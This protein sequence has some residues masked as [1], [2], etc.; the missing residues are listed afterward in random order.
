MAISISP[1]DASRLSF[2]ARCL[3][4]G[5]TYPIIAVAVD[6]LSI[7]AKSIYLDM[8]G[9]CITPCAKAYVEFGKNPNP[10]NSPMMKRN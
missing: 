6:T 3:F 7:K 4:L 10:T 1:E 5:Y 8:I 9:D 2:I